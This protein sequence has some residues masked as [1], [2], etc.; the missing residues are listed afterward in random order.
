MND[1]QIKMSIDVLL[2]YF[3]EFPE[4]FASRKKYP[5]NPKTSS[6]KKDIAEL[7]ETGL[8]QLIKPS[9]PGTK[10]D[11]ITSIIVE[12]YYDLPISN[13]KKAEEDHQKYMIAENITGHLL[14]KY[15]SDRGIRYGWINCPRSIIKSVD[16][17][18]KTNNKWRLLQIKNR[19]N[20]ENSSS[21]TV[22]ENTSIEK[23]HRFES[24][25]GVTNWENFPDNEL[26][27]ILSEK[28]FKEFV[29]QYIQNIKQNEN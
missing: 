18:K 5:P 23:W 20:S 11:T 15:I 10:P 16:F 1:N 12:A 2:S 17:I 13:R 21:K 8:T 7:I 25:T 4:Q 29:Y 19:D 26:R 27:K 24:R 14:E 28:D 6:G 22:R 9:I 3:D